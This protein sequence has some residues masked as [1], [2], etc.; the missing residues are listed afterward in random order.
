MLHTHWKSSLPSLFS[1]SSSSSSPSY[2]Y[3][4]KPDEIPNFT[5]NLTT[6]HYQSSLL[7]HVLFF[8]IIFLSAISTRTPRNTHYE[9]YGVSGRFRFKSRFSERPQEKYEHVA[10]LHSRSL[11]KCHNNSENR[12]RNKKFM[13]ENIFE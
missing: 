2:H 1:S 13:Q 9:V 5:S 11:L 6:V 12:L 10:I 3:L 4:T 7:L 8:F